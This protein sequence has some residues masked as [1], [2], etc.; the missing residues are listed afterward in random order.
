MI[1]LSIFDI[2]PAS[3]TKFDGETFDQEKDGH[4]L[5]RQYHKVWA[6]MQDRDWHTLRDIASCV[7]ASEASVSA[8]LRDF[9]KERAG[10]NIVEKRRNGDAKS[11]V[12]EYR[13][14]INGQI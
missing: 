2:R 3:P 14:L 6:Y 10:K 13:L 4:R 5:A 9:R 7:N 12:F 1:Q 8:R 11:G